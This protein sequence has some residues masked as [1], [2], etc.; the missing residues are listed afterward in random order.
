MV[1]L[2]KK[3]NHICQNPKCPYGI[4][5][6]P[7]HYYACDYCGR[8]EN[9]RSICCC[10][11]CYL[12][13]HPDGRVYYPVRT[14]KTQE[15][16]EDMMRKPVEEVLSDTLKDLNGM[17]ETISEVGIAGAIDLINERIDNEKK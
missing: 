7:K 11:E 3:P 15:E 9:W 10:R 5:G 17:E 1:V 14:D 16:V 13:L 2:E 6:A 4:D 12:Q 8:T